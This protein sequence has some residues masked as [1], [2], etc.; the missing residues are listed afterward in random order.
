M[1]ITDLFRTIGPGVEL[2]YL[3]EEAPNEWHC[4]LKLPTDRYQI[5]LVTASGIDPD[6][7][8]RKTVARAHSNARREDAA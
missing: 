8:L 5:S 3:S 6:D 4:E 7:A 1:S 2:H